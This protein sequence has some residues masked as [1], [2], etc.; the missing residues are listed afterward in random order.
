MRIYIDESG[1]HDEKWLVIGMLFVPD[2]GGTHAALCKIKED[3]QYY[4]KSPKR[5][6]RYKETHLA[7]FRSPRDV[8]VGSAWVDTFVAHSCFYRAVVI[9]WSIWD[10]RY[11]GRWY[12]TDAL[13]KRRAYKKWAEMLL[14]PEVS[15]GL[16]GNAALY[17][18]R[19]REISKYDVLAHLKERFSGK[20]IAG[21]P[22]IKSFQHTDS[23]FDA[24][25]CLQLCDLLTGCLYQHLIP[26]E[27]KEKTEMRLYLETALRPVG[28]KRMGASFWKGFAAT[29][30]RRHLPK[31]SAWFWR[32][33]DDD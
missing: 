10:G 21:A 30:L 27:S 22:C 20:Y 32:P 29:S 31:Y 16:V 19:L 1:T 11:F 17:L 33:T 25:Q 23:W 28:V 15:E 4:N 9:D 12:E 2:H 26:A 18:D 14:Q 6:A 5:P 24:N 13:K 8:M 3:I 7:D